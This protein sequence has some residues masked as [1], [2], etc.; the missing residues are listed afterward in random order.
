MPDVPLPSIPE[1]YR[2]TSEFRLLAACS[3]IAPPALEQEQARQIVALCRGGIDWDVFVAL[4]RRHGVPALAYFV[5]CRYAVECLPDE[6]RETLRERNSASRL[7]ALFQAA[8]LARLIK[9]FAGHGIAV[10]PLKGVF[11]SHQLYGD[12]GMRSSVDLDILVRPEHVDLADQTLEAE[13][14]SCDYHGRQLTARQKRQFRTHLP[15]YDFTH[16]R[17]GLHVELHWNFGLWL[18]GQMTDFLLHTT[19]REWQGMP[20]A[21]LDDDAT[22]LLLCEHGARHL[23]SSMKW[24]GDVA[25][26]L[27]SE[28]ATGWDTLLERA[29][30]FDLRRIL[31]HSALMVHWVYGVQLPHE[32]CRLIQQEDLAASLS[33]RALTRMLMS[34]GDSAFA[35]KRARK[36]RET[37]HLKRMRPSVSYCMIAK[38]CL[39]SPDDY[40][41]LTLPASLFWLYYPLRPILWFWRNYMNK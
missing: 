19:Q 21:C 28:R 31:A 36:L 29:T 4:V 33:E 40:Q 23:W 41:I 2:L 27:S 20:V 34:G 37:L 10:I 25:R 6:V 7:Q 16:S 5:L 22:L 8:E 1:K 24:L 30:E 11:L 35:G 32:L 17:T 26:L 9:L 38:Y 39:V 15:H 13:G 18:P 14:Y 3:W 12:T